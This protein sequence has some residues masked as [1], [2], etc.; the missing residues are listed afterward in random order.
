MKFQILAILSLALLACPAA[1]AS[2]LGVEVGVL[3][4][5][6]DLGDVADPSPYIGGSFEIQDINPLGQVAVMSF[7]VR[8]GFSPLQTSS[9]IETALEALGGGSDDGSLFDIGAGVRVHSAVNPLFAT[10]GGSWVTLDPAG[11]G[12]S[13]GGLGGFVGIG[14]S[15]GPPTVKINFEGRANLA[16]IDSNSVQFFQLLASAAFPF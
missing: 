13:E 2:G 5:A 14:A 3:M 1:H 11:P 15:F 4:P 16:S 12:D 9:S 10:A 6:G 7:I 8:A